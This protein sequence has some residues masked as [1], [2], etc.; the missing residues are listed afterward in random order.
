M[1]K[2]FAGFWILLLVA[3]FAVGP[4]V[5]APKLT[6]NWHVVGVQIAPVAYTPNEGPPPGSDPAIEHAIDTDMTLNQDPN[7]PALYYGTIG[8]HAI[9]VMMEA[10]ANCRFT[11]SAPNG[12]DYFNYYQTDTG[13]VTITYGNATASPKKI[14]GSFSNEKGETGGFTATRE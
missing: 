3:V 7:N 6:G 5:A 1:K 12:P 11:I 9:T 4:A 2:S 8:P 14:V 10:G 13:F